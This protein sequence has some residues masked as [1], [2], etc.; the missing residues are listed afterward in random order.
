MPKL[1]STRR[2]AAQLLKDAEDSFQDALD[3]TRKQK[4]RMLEIRAAVGL[5][6]LWQRQGKQQEALQILEKL[7]HSF[8][9][10]FDTEDLR[11]AHILIEELRESP[12]QSTIKV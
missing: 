9:E 8:T 5:G 7:Y 3:L 12:G 2:Q 4:A 11:E 10:G 1:R 6:R